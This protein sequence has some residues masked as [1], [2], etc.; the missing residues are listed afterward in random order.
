MSTTKGNANKKRDI[1]KT[2]ADKAAKDYW[3]KYYKD[4]GYG[5]LWVRDIPRKVKAALAPS[6]SRK[7]ASAEITIEPFTTVILDDVVVLEGRATIGKTAHVF[8]ADFDHDGNIRVFTS[9][10]LV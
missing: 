9:M 7:V 10:Q 2:A 4:T 6:L 5:A 3:T 1:P 8:A